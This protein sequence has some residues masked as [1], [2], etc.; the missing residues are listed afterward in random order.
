MS[1]RDHQRHSA[2][3]ELTEEVDRRDEA[4]V[5]NAEIN[6][7]LPSYTSDRYGRNEYDNCATRI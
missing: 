2:S 4:R 3:I 5:E 7:C 6:V 1:V